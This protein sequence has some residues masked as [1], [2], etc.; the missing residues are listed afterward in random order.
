MHKTF[1]IK[2]YKEGSHGDYQSQDFINYSET[3]SQH[4]PSSCGVRQQLAKFIGVNQTFY[5]ET[6]SFGYIQEKSCALK[7][8]YS[9]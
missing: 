9:W 7:C 2:R 4:H 1:I 3:I 6:K 5:K 8:K